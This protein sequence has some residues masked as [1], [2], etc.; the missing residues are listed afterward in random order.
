VPPSGLLLGGVPTVAGPAQ[1]T[2]VP[3]VVRVQAGRDQLAP[4]EWPVVGVDA[5][6]LPAEDARRVLGEDAGSEPGLVLLAVAALS[7]GAALLLGLGS[8]LRA[9]AGVS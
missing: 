7:G 2:A 1:A 4:A 9:A 3:R 6:R 5:G 8:M